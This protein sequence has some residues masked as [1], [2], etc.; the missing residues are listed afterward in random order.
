MHPG[1]EQQRAEQVDHH[2]HLQRIPHR[3]QLLLAQGIERPDRR[4]QQHHQDP[5]G[6]VAQGCQQLAQALVEEQ[7]ETDQ[8]HQQADALPHTEPFLEHEQA[9]DQQHD[10]PHLHHQLRGAGAQ[11]VQAHQVTHVVAHQ[12]EHRHRHQPA[13]AWA[14]DLATGQAPG[15]RQIDEQ[16]T[17]GH[18]QA[19]PGHG[20]RVHHLQHLLEL[21][22]QDSPEQGSQQG[23]EQTV[24]PA[25]GRY[26][27][28]TLEAQ[29][30]GRP[31]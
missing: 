11:A 30:K 19:K 26:V 18:H 28:A 4:R 24:D 22:R 27:H 9:G 20:D 16:Q 10:R 17:A 14:K 15:G 5:G 12:P 23:E 2:H 1:R 31:F 25:T 13:A 3:Q 7:R 21:D 29:D 8:Q 6:V